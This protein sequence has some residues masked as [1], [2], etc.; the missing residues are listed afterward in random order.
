MKIHPVVRRYIWF[1]HNTPPLQ[2]VRRTLNA[3]AAPVRDMGID[4]RRFDI[5]MAK[6]FLDCS[7]IVATFEQVSGKGMAECLA[8]NHTFINLNLLNN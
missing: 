1:L 3:L 4:H 8:S 7:D 6:K 2:V 5:V